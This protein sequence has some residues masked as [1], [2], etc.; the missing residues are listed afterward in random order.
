MKALFEPGSIAVIG[1]AREE[2]KLGNIILRNLI[3]SGFEGGL[4]PVNPKADEIL[5]MKCYPSISEISDSV[6]LIVVV[7]PNRIVRERGE[8]GHNH[9]GRFQGDRS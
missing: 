9:H 6:D 5:G 7:V 2:G 8:G 1:A 3:S 4:Y